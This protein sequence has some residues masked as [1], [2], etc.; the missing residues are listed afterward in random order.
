MAHTD[1][2]DKS[3]IIYI[4]DHVGLPDIFRENLQ[5]LGLTVYALVTPNPKN[6][7]SL[8]DTVLHN[9]R[10]IFKRDWT[11]KNKVFAKNRQHDIIQTNIKILNKIRGKTD[12]ALII[13]PDLLSDDVIK[14]VKN[15]TV[16]IIGYQWDGLDRFP[17]VYDKIRFFDQF[18]V[19]DKKDLA[20][21]KRCKSI[22][23][24]YFDHLFGQEEI[25]NTDVYFIGSYVESRMQ[26]LTDLAV[27]FKDNNFI[28]DINIIGRQKKHILPPVVTGI[29]HSTEI[30][31]FKKNYQHIKKTKAVLDLIDDAHTG[32]SFRVFEAIGFKKKLITNNPEVA[33]YDFYNPNNIFVIGERNIEDIKDFMQIPFEELPEDIHRKYGFENWLRN[34]LD[35]P[36]YITIEEQHNHTDD[37]NK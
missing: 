15:T 33:K 9:F 16:K 1:L 7:I 14:K 17:A 20:V 25:R 12:Y 6:R 32:L 13:R 22:T 3:I 28:S 8:K 11:Y 21:D 35:I 31:D 23:N 2:G 26:I 5:S 18:F 10:K 19:F 27:F 36:E 34:I 29:N 4:P 30:I 37:N 24:F